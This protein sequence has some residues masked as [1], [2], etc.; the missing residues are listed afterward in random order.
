MWLYFQRFKSTSA[1][2]FYVTE[3]HLRT[4][5]N[6]CIGNSVGCATAWHTVRNFASPLRN[7]NT[8]LAAVAYLFCRRA[9][10]IN[11]TVL[12]NWP[13]WYEIQL[14][15]YFFLSHCDV[16]QYVQ[17]IQLFTLP[18]LRLSLQAYFL[19]YSYGLRRHITSSPD[20][21]LA[22]K[23]PSRSDTRNVYQQ[24]LQCQQSHKNVVVT[25]KNTL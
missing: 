6:T 4:S 1:R 13:V 20:S 25:R 23:K 9:L 14:L 18:A 7:Q 19:K 16:K 15:F 2:N 5:R 8:N 17:Q 22:R 21:C 12:Q 10:I 24:H 11:R 3:C